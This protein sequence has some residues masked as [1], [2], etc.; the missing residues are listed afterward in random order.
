MIEGLLQG[1]F[2]V[3]WGEEVEKVYIPNYFG[4]LRKD[5]LEL[6]FCEALYLLEKRQISIINKNKKMNREEFEKLAE[7]L[8]TEFKEKY[9][10]Y[11]DLRDKGLLV[12]SG[13]KFGTHFRV[14]EKGVELKRGA[15]S[16]KEHTKWIVHAIPE[17]FTW[18]F[19]ELS[20]F[21]R[22]ALNIR[23]KPILGVV[24]KEVN[25]Y[26]IERIKM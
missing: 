19:P 18:T 4:K 23:S 9:R 22:L 7:T 13:F 3:V 26:K 12:R 24:G 21:V 1:R 8:D 16:P 17:N 14:Y 11:K 6:N 5:R 10:V 20:R 2:V 15:K 25:Y